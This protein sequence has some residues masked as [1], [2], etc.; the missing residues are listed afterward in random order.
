MS[1]IHSLSGGLGQT[2]GTEGLRVWEGGSEGVRHVYECV[3]G[4]E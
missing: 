1:C 4:R 2:G 3:G